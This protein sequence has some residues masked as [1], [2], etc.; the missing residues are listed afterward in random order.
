MMKI[1]TAVIFVLSRMILADTSTEIGN[2]RIECSTSGKT[3]LRP[4]CH[5][6]KSG[7]SS[8]VVS[9]GCDLQRKLSPVYVSFSY[10]SR[11]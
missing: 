3:C 7:Q 1:S 10:L 8:D 9:F 11:V 2:T 4:Y 5:L 6:N